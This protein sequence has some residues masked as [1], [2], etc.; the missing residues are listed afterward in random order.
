MGSKRAVDT[1]DQRDDVLGFVS[2]RDNDG[3]RGHGK[4]P[5]MSGL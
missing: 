3:K 2:R 1:F 4:A 5:R